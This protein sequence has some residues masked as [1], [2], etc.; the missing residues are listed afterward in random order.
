MEKGGNKIRTVKRGDVFYADLGEGVGSEQSGVRP[1][2]VIQNNVGNRFSP[3]VIIASI[4]SKINKLKL[5]THIRLGEYDGLIKGSIVLLEQIR[6]I[7][8]ERLREYRCTLSKED[9]KRINEGILI[10]LEL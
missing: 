1:V 5:P 4:T 2:V 10:S 8:K 9:L 3:T 6:A 7:D